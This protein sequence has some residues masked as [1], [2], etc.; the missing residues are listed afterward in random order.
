VVEISLPQCILDLFAPWADVKCWVVCNENKQ[1][2]DKRTGRLAKWRTDPK[3][4]I[5]DLNEL[6]TLYIYGVVDL[7]GGFGIILG[8]DNLLCCIDFDHVLD[9]N[10]I[11][12]NPDVL[13]FITSLNT[14][15]EK[16]SSGKGLH[17]FLY[18]DSPHE[19]YGLKKTFCDGKF[20]VDRFIKMTGNVFMN[21][22]FPVKK[23]DDSEFEM[24]KARVGEP[25]F[26]NKPID[27]DTDGTPFPQHKTPIRIVSDI[28]ESWETILR[29][30]GIVIIHSNYTGKVRRGKHV[31]ESWR[32][33]CPNKRCHATDRPGDPSA[34]L[35]ILN[36]YSD[37]TTS[38]SC[39]HNSCSPD[40][41]PNLLQKLWDSIK[42]QGRKSKLISSAWR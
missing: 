16:S 2:C 25:A 14:F 30:A 29:D 41:H 8:Q 22:N 40:K 37:G 20:Y 15:V 39:S 17:A 19:E 5:I 36:K 28:N 18:L 26:C 1:P 7:W 38:V 35:A 6:N 31:V 21:N 3:D 27:E 10:G 24:I 32:I 23:I 9:E 12:I 33:V 42:S 34:H 4:N 13:D 11:P